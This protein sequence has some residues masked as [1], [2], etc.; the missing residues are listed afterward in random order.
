MAISTV[1][2]CCLFDAALE[3]DGHALETWFM[4]F[5]YNTVIGFGKK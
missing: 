3:Q 5:L 4:A 1:S 2:L